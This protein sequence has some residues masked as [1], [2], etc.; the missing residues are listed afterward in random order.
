VRELLAL[1]SV[2]VGEAGKDNEYGFGLVDAL[3]AVAAA[4]GAPGGATE[5]PLLDPVATSVANNGTWTH[6]FDVSQDYVDQQ[7][8]IAATVTIEGACNNGIYSGIFGDACLAG[9][10]WWDPDLELVVERNT[11]G[12]N[13]QQVPADVDPVSQI[14]EVTLSECPARGECWNSVGRVEVVHFI[15]NVAGL[16]RM[17]V[18]PSADPGSNNGA[19]GNFSFEFSM[20]EAGPP[21]DNPPTASFTYACTDLACS[22]TDTSTDDGAVVGWSWD[23]GDGQT[24]TAQNPSVTYGDG[25]TFTP[26]SPDR[27]RFNHLLKHDNLFSSTG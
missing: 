27:C 22:F 15:P 20:L 24:S 6:E 11:G 19:G 12:A 16:H 17:R 3:A 5:Y 18:W 2:D 26:H 23:F 1:T 8:P 21:V 25:G 13:W 9:I 10:S 4:S 7:L 14:G